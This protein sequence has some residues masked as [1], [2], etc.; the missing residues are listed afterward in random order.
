MEERLKNQL[1]VDGAVMSVDGTDCVINELVLFI[2]MWFSQK[3]HGS[4]VRYE[5]GVPNVTDR[6]VWVNGP[7]PADKFPDLMIFKKD[8]FQKL[9]DG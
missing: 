8:L 3:F 4:S 1:K 7:L 2:P 9:P 6:I 5:I